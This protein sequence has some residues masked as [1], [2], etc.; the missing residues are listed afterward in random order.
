MSIA[1]LSS[2]LKIFGGQSSDSDDEQRLP[3]EA[4][5][6]TLARAAGTDTNISPVEISS[7]QRAMKAAT[8]QDFS[9]ADVRLAAKSE[10]FA[11]Q[12]LK[13]VL[14]KI[15]GRL[16]TRDRIMIANSLAEVIRSDRRVN[17]LEQDYFDEVAAAL[18]VR[19][20]E[21]AGLIVDA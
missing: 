11:N 2:V 10:L 20:S 14:S 15:S 12:S 6:M 13:H 3:T 9:E 4:L 16:T 8:G 7:V 18:K 17:E 5:L 21:L 1:S 19:P